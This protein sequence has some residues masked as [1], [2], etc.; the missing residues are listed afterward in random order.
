MD[1]K[2]LN[3]IYFSGTGNT[4]TLVDETISFF[5]EKDY[6]INKF[7]LENLKDVSFLNEDDINCIAFPVAVHTTYPFVREFI[8]ELPIGKFNFFVFTTLAGPYSGVPKYIKNEFSKKGYNILGI[9]EIT[10]PSNL[11]PKSIDELKNNSIKTKAIDKL[12]DFLE[13]VIN[14]NKDIPKNK[15]LTDM[16]IP[17]ANSKWIWNFMQKFLKLHID[18]N[19]CINCG[20]CSRIC[21]VSNIIKEDYPKIMDNCQ[22]CMR[23]ISY[24]PK[25]AIKSGK[26]DFMQYKALPISKL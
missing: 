16:F 13:K 4:K 19:E 25:K 17:V 5:E 22:S 15:F 6:T 8:E 10:M 18:E 23:C 11:V 26:K 24:C 7:K 21:P 2:V 14:Q 3:I 12:K 1:K 20:L 9:K